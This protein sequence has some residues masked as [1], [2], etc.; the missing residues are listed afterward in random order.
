MCLTSLTQSTSIH[1]QADLKSELRMQCTQV[2][3]GGKGTHEGLGSECEQ[4]E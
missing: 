1:E 4:N 2:G 3:L